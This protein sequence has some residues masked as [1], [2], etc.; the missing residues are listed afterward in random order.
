MKVLNNRSCQF[1]ASALLAAMLTAC[2]G[3]GS[4]S[5]GSD[6]NSDSGKVA[7]GITDAEGDFLSYSV[8]VTSIKLV[9]ANGTT[10]EVVPAA[11]R[12]DFAQ[13]T[14][15]TEFFSIATVPVGEYVSATMVLDYSN[16]DIFVENAAGD[17]VEAAPLDADGNPLTTLQVSIDLPQDKPLNVVA[18]APA[19]MVIDF[20]LAASNEVT[21]WS[22]V[23]VTVDSVLLADVQW[24]GSRELRA[25]G[26]LQS[27]DATANEFDIELLPFNHHGGEFGDATVQVADTTIYHVNGADY[28]GADGLAALAALGAD[29]P[30]VVLGDVSNSDDVRTYSAEF[31]YAGTSVPW[32]G[33]DAIKGTVLARSG[34]TL[35]VRGMAFDGDDNYEHFHDD[36]VVN[37]ADDT[38][39][40][41]QI[42][43]VDALDTD[44]I[45]VGSRIEL[46]GDLFAAGDAAVIDTTA[47]LVHILVSEVTGKVEHIPSE[48]TSPLVLDV[49][50]INRRDAA[51]Y[52][53]SGTGIDASSDAD[54]SFYEID[55]Q[56]LLLNDITVGEWVMLRGFASAYGSAPADFIAYSVTDPAALPESAH[57]ILTWPHGSDTAIVELSDEHMVVDS[58]GANEN[59]MVCG[60]HREDDHRAHHFEA[61]GNGQGNGNGNGQD[62]GQ[63]N[64][65]GEGNA[66]AGTVYTIVPADTSSAD[67]GVY[68]IKRRGGHNVK[69]YGDFAAFSQTL[70]T[71]LADGGVVRQVHVK[72]SYN[73]ETGVVSAE[74]I[75]VV[76]K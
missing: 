21:S 46:V 11:T 9:K 37:L 59:F 60:E 8:D 64:D 24:D 57:L 76:L 73:D 48:L 25:R 32:A 69:L 4:G 68:S 71:E 67:K 36:I 47:G 55:T 65:D 19:N 42:P 29:A 66:A 63:G 41:R 18:G 1:A 10:V 7:L 30:V 45:S 40:T 56:S 14:N 35:I 70:A 61:P 26:L 15:V 23:Q 34:D 39:V 20:D 31:V 62:Q 75:N 44:A 2:G 53:F 49:A 58:T 50:T 13:Y 27:V 38:T 6:N 72:G 28:S 33:R 16:A 52:D 54:P 74:S 12:I 5:N 17:A 3:G 51:V 43:S 22:P